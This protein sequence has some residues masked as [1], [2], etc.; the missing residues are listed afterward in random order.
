MLE[1]LTDSSVSSAPVTL[2]TMGI[3]LIAAALFGTLVAVAY[4]LHRRPVPIP[5]TFQLTLVLLSI[6]IAMVMQVIDDRVARAFSLV[7][8][9]SIVRFRTV[10]DDTQDIAF[11]IFAVVVGMAAGT[12]ALGV[13][14][15][16][17]FVMIGTLA[18]SKVQFEQRPSVSSEND[19]RNKTELAGQSDSVAANLTLRIAVT[20]D[21][22]NSV[23]PVLEANL[24]T[25][26]LISAETARG[27]SVFEWTYAVR[28]KPEIPV[29]VL[30]DRCGKTEGILHVEIK[31]RDRIA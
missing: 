2:V 5:A 27:G 12:G 21:F 19:S 30:L 26:R 7:G 14:L 25:F 4:R 22:Q 16:G 31:M 10:L 15:L 3:R 13:A 23:I 24:E 20:T 9:L 8:A 28:M 6:L 18:L 1:W 29:N 17:S 11:V